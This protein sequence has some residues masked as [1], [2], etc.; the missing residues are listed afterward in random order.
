MAP[1]QSPA[2][3]SPKTASWSSQRRG[4]GTLQPVSVRKMNTGKARACSSSWLYVDCSYELG[5][6]YEYELRP[7]KST[8]SDALPPHIR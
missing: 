6:H 7:K 1:L 8:L 4:P 5:S 3:D 2:M